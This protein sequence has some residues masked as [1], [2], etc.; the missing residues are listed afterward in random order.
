[1]TAVFTSCVNPIIYGLYFHSEKKVITRYLILSDVTFIS[2]V[3]D[4]IRRPKSV[5]FWLRQEFKKCR[6]VFLDCWLR[7]LNID[8]S[9]LDLQAAILSLKVIFK[10]S[11][12]GL[13]IGKSE[14]KKRCLV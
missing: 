10:L 13:R 4:T 11:S 3:F 9:G 5:G 6:S 14:S 7:T 12:A 2:L 1:M 8:L